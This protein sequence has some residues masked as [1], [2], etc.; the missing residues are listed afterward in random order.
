[1]PKS[2][3]EKIV[4]PTA[5]Q[6]K[7][8]AAKE[9]LIE[10]IRSLV[11]QYQNIFLIECSHVRNVFLKQIKEDLGDAGKMMMG[12]N[13]LIA[14]A[15]GTTPEQEMKQGLSEVSK[16][17]V[18]SVGLI[19]TSKSQGEIQELLAAHAYADW[20]RCGAVAEEAVELPEG[21]L[22]EIGGEQQAISH[23]QEA[24]LRSLGMPTKLKNGVVSLERDFVVCSVGEKLTVNQTNML[25]ALQVQLAK[26]T[27]SMLGSYNESDGLV[28]VEREGEEMEVE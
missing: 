19:F 26:V 13:K 16:R 22:F 27:V 5:T 2:K 3:R 28:E 4:H 14:K 11:E 7:G 10:K 15:L 6:K 23:T 24:Y 1:M 20:A 18:G 25:R 21:P 12:K 17:L 9:I 8:K